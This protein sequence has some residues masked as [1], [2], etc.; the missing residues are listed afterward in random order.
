MLQTRHKEDKFVVGCDL[1]KE[2]WTFNPQEIKTG[3]RNLYEN[4][5]FPNAGSAAGLG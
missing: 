2:F 4:P 5:L 1:R 3:F